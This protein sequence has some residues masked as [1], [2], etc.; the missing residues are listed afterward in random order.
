MSR[1]KLTAV[2][3]LVN[4]PIQVS[5]WSNQG[6]IKPR[7][8][9]IFCKLFPEIHLPVN[10][11]KC[12]SEA[13]KPPLR[14]FIHERIRVPS[15]V[16]Q[17]ALPLAKNSTGKSKII[18]KFTQDSFAYQLRDVVLY[19]GGGGHQMQSA[20]KLGFRPNK[21]VSSIRIPKIFCL[22]AV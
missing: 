21:G 1:T 20:K 16:H 11:T 7:S 12:Q 18:H 22:G 19:P 2:F 4:S 14:C 8:R 13:L 9:R 6:G 3:S 17:T 5:H 10:C 15:I